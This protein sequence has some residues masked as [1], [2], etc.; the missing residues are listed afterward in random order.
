MTKEDINKTEET[1]EEVAKTEEQSE[2]QDQENGT[3]ESTESKEEYVEPKIKPEN[4]KLKDLPGIGATSIEKLEKAGILSVMAFACRTPNLISD[5]T[6]VS[7]SAARK[8]IQF[9]KDNLDELN[10][11]P[12]SKYSKMKKE[13]YFLPTGSIELD[14]LL[15]GGIRSGSITEAHAENG[16]SKSQLG[17]TLAINTVIKGYK[18]IFLDTE[19]A[20]KE[21]RLKTILDAKRLEY[22]K[23]WEGGD[24]DGTSVKDIYDSFE[25]FLDKK[26]G[27]KTLDEEDIFDNIIFSSV[28]N[29]SLQMLLIEDVDRLCSK[30]DSVKLLIIDSLTEHFRSEFLGRGELNSRQLQINKHMS[31][32]K[33]LTKRHNLA[34]YLTN[35]VMSDP[36]QMF[37][38]PIKPIGGNVYAHKL[39]YRLYLKRGKQNTRIAKLIKA[40]DLSDG[41]CPFQVLEV[42]VTDI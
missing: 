4:L 11:N 1:I 9:A 25:D 23:A 34:V 29:S 15:G 10:L 35:Q 30:D 2:S 8:A 39:D 36:G 26:F 19:N 27:V 33:R 40:R 21:D 14:N 28:D 37:G 6:G 41:E 32:I 16:V 18:V 22:E 13:T 38:D 3:K 42:G 5:F 31:D 24:E 7:Q 12:L 17:L 20:F